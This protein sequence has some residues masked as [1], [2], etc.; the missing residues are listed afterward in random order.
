ML[1]LKEDMNANKIKQGDKV[2]KTPALTKKY[3]YGH[4]NCWY[5]KSTI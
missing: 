2:K 1:G 5:N 3:E 4:L